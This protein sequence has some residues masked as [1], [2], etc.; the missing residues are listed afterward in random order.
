MGTAL[1]FS[2]MG[3]LIICMAL[4]P[5]LTAS[6]WRLQFVDVPRERH[7]HDAPIAKVGG[8]AF[9]VATI[10]AVLLW[11]PK[12]QLIL[13]SL[14]GG[15]IILLFG[16]WDDRVGL[17]YRMKFVGQIAAAAVVIG[18]AGVRLTVPFM[19]EMS[20]PAWVAVPLTMVVILGMTNAVNLADGLD[21]LAGGLSLISFAGIAYL[22]YQAN[23]PLLVLLMVS[24]LGGL[25][26]FLRFNTYPAK[27]FMGDAGSQFLGLY[28]AVAAILLTDS[29]RT[30]Y[31][32]LLALFIWGVPLLDTIGVMGQRLFE[33]RSPFV[34][35]RNHIHHKLLARGM[36]HGQAVTLI[37]LAHG[38]MVSC[39]YLLRWQS[40]V[41]LMGVY[42]LCAAAILSMFVR[43]PHQVIASECLDGSRTSS[44]CVQPTD[45]VGDPGVAAQNPPTGG[46]PVSHRIGG[47]AEGSSMG[48][49]DD[50]CGTVGC[51]GG[52][53]GC[54]PRD[55]M[56]GAGWSLC[57]EHV[58]DVLR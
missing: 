11:A 20:L 25:L 24:V 45:S 36:T 58:P 7:A 57:R 56:G 39:A 15:A 48:C 13:A 19:D 51:N 16:V 8:I 31:G 55:G 29:T 44:S 17:D 52:F 27:I 53:N 14:L 18:F 49:R 30:A 23:E 42:L 6:A 26:G 50:R 35:D 3:S 5:A 38:V 47:D 37:Y 10:A 46:S 34:G 22:A 12:D 9:A 41:V 40:D 4:I 32:P 33:G 43:K 2:F 1:F 21:G 54:G 28:L